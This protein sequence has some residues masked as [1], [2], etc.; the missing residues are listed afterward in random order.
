MLKKKI[1]S[2]LLSQMMILSAVPFAAQTT[3]NEIGR[4]HV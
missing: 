4:A 3:A 2:A 1:M